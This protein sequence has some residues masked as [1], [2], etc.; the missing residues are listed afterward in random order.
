MQTRAK[1]KSVG[2]GSNFKW[3]LISYQTKL[4]R[5]ATNKIS[6]VRFLIFKKALIPGRKE[7]WIIFSST[8]WNNFKKKRERKI[9]TF[10]FD[11]WAG[12]KESLLL[13]IPARRNRSLTFCFRSKKKLEGNLSTIMFLKKSGKITFGRFFKK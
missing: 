7:S 11:F 4:I 10:V 3:T 5:A 1:Y 2:A 8:S 6:S 12:K 13:L 9:K